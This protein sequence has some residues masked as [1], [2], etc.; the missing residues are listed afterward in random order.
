MFLVSPGHGGASSLAVGVLAGCLLHVVVCRPARCHLVVE[1][2]VLLWRGG[3][4]TRA[5]GAKRPPGGLVCDGV[6]LMFVEVRVV[7]A[8]HTFF[9]EGHGPCCHAECDPEECLSADLFGAALA[10]CAAY[11]AFACVVFEVLVGHLLCHDGDSCV[12]G[13]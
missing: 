13:F 8:V 4:F 11:A 5:G 7:S 10:G 2:G 6:G 1:G 12:R 9:E 3:A